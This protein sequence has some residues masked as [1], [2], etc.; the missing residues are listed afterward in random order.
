MRPIGSWRFSRKWKN[1]GTE[2]EEILKNGDYKKMANF[3]RKREISTKMAS[4][5][6]HSL[7]V[8]PNI[9]IR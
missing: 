4:T 1:E 2:Q 8:W 5:A 6:K 7:R 9:Q 3:G